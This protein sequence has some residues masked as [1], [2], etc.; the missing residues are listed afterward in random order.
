M[1][2]FTL[3]AVAVCFWF[4]RILRSEDGVWLVNLPA[5]IVEIYAQPV[6]GKYQVAKQAKRS[7][8]LLPVSVSNFALSVDV[9]LG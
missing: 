2:R 6:G 5:D 3:N 4:I 8:H 1:R 9:V 7:E